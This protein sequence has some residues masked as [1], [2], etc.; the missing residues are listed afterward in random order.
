[1]CKYRPGINYR[2]CQCYFEPKLIKK[3]EEVIALENLYRGT[4]LRAKKHC[5][6]PKTIE[7]P[8]RCPEHTKAKAK[9]DGN[10]VGGTAFLDGFIVSICDLWVWI[11]YLVP[12]IAR[13]GTSD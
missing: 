13:A 9:K 4:D 6:R 8:G 12:A 1:M 10:G 7:E 11:C 3:C 5:D 2:R